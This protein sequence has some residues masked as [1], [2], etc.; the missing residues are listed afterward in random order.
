MLYTHKN[1]RKKYDNDMN[2]E[3]SEWE[4]ACGPGFSK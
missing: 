4:T 3:K 1:Y 2:Y